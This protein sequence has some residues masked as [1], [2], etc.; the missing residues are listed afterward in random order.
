MGRDRFSE[1]AARVMLP[2]SAMRTNVVICSNMG[3]RSTLNLHH[4]SNM[5]GRIDGTEA[6]T[7]PTLALPNLSRAGWP[8]GRAVSVSRRLPEE[9]AERGLARN[10]P[11]GRDYVVPSQQEWRPGA[12]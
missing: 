3:T 1:R 11:P 12:S 7:P 9:G 6:T 2:I 10:A 4:S 5:Y 8:Q